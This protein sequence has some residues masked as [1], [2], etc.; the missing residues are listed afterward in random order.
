M[1]VSRFWKE[2]DRQAK[3]TAYVSFR[4]HHFIDVINVPYEKDGRSLS[5]AYHMLS[6]LRKAYKPRDQQHTHIVQTMPLLG[7]KS[8][9]WNRNAEVLYIT[10][11]QLTNV[12]AISYE[13]LNTAI[14]A[15]LKQNAPAAEFS[16]YQ[17]LDFCDFVLFTKN[18]TLEQQQ[19]LLWGFT[20]TGDVGPKVVRDTF[21]I[22]SFGWDYLSCCFSGKSHTKWNDTIATTINL[23]IQSLTVTT[24]LEEKLLKEG[25]KYHAA[26]IGGRY[27][28]TVVTEPIDGETVMRLLA[29]VDQLAHSDNRKKPLVRSL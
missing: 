1:R 26:R 12:S 9:F 10:F 4:S 29:T 27:D 3:E 14:A 15:Y 5:S 23:G 28:Y 8:A 25:I 6:D 18:I 7:W 21:T 2:L 16:L 22:F 19:N 20:L 17:S 11:I 24:L 13:A